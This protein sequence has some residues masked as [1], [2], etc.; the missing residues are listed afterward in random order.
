MASGNLNPLSVPIP[1]FTGRKY[2]TWRIK[3]E[4]YFLS[5]DLWDIVNEG[6]SVPDNTS[7][8]SERQQKQLKESRQKNAAALYILLQAVEYDIFSKIYEV[9]TAKGAWTALKKEFQGNTQ[10]T[11]LSDEDREQCE[12]YLSLYKAILEGNL[13]TVQQI[14]HDNKEALRARITVNWDTALHVAV[15]IGTCKANDIV[16][17][18]LDQMP[19]DDDLLVK[20]NKEG[21]TILS[22]AA[23]V[24]NVRAAF[25]ILMKNKHKTL[26]QDSNN[27]KRIPLI[28]AARHGQ[29][30]M[31]EFLLPF[32]NSYFDYADLTGFSDDSGVSFLN[33]LIIA[34]FYG[35]A[36]KVLQIHGNLAT[37]QLPTGEFVL[38]TIAGKPSAFRSG[39]Q[40]KR[41]FLQFFKDYKSDKRE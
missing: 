15:G 1:I 38:S 22:V 16:K 39:Q 24:G 8:L 25:M 5:Q 2:D 10:P 29:K 37:K 31:I 32:S 21:N 20:K 33:S 23:I 12:K 17:Y 28:E 35:L 41:K 19:I 14:C 27:S 13:E 30:K 18:L 26:I 4:T 40:T 36:L 6:I 11:A 3:M 7:T 9:K 34:G